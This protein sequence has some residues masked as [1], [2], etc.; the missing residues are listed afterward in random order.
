MVKSVKAAM[1]ALQESTKGSDSPL[2]KFV[3]TGGSKRGWTSWLVGALE[4]PR[5]VG[6]APA[7]FDNLGFVEQLA[8]QKR[9]WGAYSP[10]IADYTDRGLQEMLET[11]RGKKLVQLVD[12][13][14]SLP[15]VPV[16]VLTATNDP[17]WTVDSTQ[18]YWSKLTMPKWS[19]AIPNAGHT[20]GDR[21]WWAPSLALFAGACVTGKA[22]PEVWSELT[23][24]DDSWS[25][26][27]DCSP[28]PAAYKVWHTTSKDLHFD[29]MVWTV[30][31]EKSV[32]AS[33]GKR[34]IWVNG[35]RAKTLNTAVL[36]ELEY[37]TKNG[38]LR[39]MTPVYLA[40]KR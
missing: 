39:L 24:E 26:R 22:L 19:I 40:P 14:Q 2:T 18:G 34:G 21:K 25:L 28:G 20:M 37:E 1:D 31:E 32:P 3:V 29:Q 17:Y 10:M 5:V 36:V 23:L 12:P 27:I 15:T 38:K 33:D 30:A 8:Q 6:I 11:E 9:Y 7:V 16:M 4:D 13:L 35:D